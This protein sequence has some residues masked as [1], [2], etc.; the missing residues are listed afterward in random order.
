MPACQPW[1]KSYVSAALRTCVRSYVLGKS[2]RPTMRVD[3][4]SVYEMYPPSRF[5]SLRVIS[6]SRP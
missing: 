4:E 5:V 3:R 2:A 6:I 1:P